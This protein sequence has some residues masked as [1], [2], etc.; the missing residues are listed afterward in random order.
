MRRAGS[1]VLGR[2][3]RGE[4][5]TPSPTDTRLLYASPGSPPPGL[6]HVVPPQTNEVTG[7]LEGSTI[8]GSSSGP[9]PAFPHDAQ[10]PLLMWTAPD[11]ATEQRGPGG[12][13]RE[14]AAR[15]GL[16]AAN[17]RCQ[18]S[19]RRSSPPLR[20]PVPCSLRG[21]AREPR[22][23]PAGAGPA[24]VPLPQPVRAAAGPRASAMGGRGAVPARAQKVITTY[25]VSHWAS[26]CPP[27]P[28]SDPPPPGC[29][30]GDSAALQ[31]PPPGTSSPQK[32]PFPGGHC[33][34]ELELVSRNGPRR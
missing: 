16:R 28:P 21:G 20:P 17:L 31:S 29:C 4:T 15:G 7:W 14:A 1:R 3:G 5:P 2:A 25:Q 26:L 12:L 32:S 22:P 30:A 13:H 34:P 10:S 19:R 24:V 9:H 27:S 6:T 8:Y 33:S 23:L 18:W 11:P